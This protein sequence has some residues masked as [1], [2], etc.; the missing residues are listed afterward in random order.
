MANAPAKV[1]F[2]DRETLPPETTLA[3]LAFPHELVAF[4]RTSLAQ[5]AERIRDADIVITNKVKVS[6]EAIAGAPRL[7]LIAVA[8]T[9]TDVI[10]LKAA[11]ARSIAVVN[12]RDYA[13]HTVPEHTFAL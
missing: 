13:V 10:D 1:V 8:A 12:V 7:K 2:L 9:G 5:V 3:A 6:G 4:G 11:E